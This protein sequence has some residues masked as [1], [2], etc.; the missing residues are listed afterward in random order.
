MNPC[1]VCGNEIAPGA[2]ICR[3]CGSRQELDASSG[4]RAK[5]FSHRTVNLE[6]GMPFVEPAINHLLIVLDEAR[7]RGISALTIIH[8]YGSSGK[9]G[10]IR[11]EC[12]KIL[13]HMCLKGE[14]HCFIPGE[15]FHRRSGKVKNLINRYPL[16]SENKNL[17]KNNQGIT[18]V[19]L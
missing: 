3:Y 16:L 5:S 4:K 9:G 19:I 12:R 15:E 14:L 10:A 13:D 6:R 17:N 1:E 11:C 8:G 18:L 2:S 7:S